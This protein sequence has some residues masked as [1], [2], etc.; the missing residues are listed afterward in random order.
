MRQAKGLQGEAQGH[1]GA[2]AGAGGSISGLT[3][4]PD[5][6]GDVTYITASGGLTKA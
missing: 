5:D 1:K 2:A 6:H 4:L 3:A